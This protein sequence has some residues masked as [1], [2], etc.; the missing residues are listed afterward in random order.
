MKEKIGIF[1]VIG[2][3][4]YAYTEEI[5]VE[6]NA[7]TRMTGIIDSRYAH[8]DV[9][10]KDMENKFPGADFATYPRGRVVYDIREKVAILYVDE[11]ITN[12][13]IAKI[14][15]KFALKNP[16]IAYD[17]HYTCDQ[18]IMDKELF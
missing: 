18:C 12:G 8:F 14:C 7:Y 1:W 13:E 16:K 9:W 10:D 11:C 3:E 15:A 5:S 4:V 6:N 2:G 17:E